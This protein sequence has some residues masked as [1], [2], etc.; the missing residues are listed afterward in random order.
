MEELY[1][2]NAA[3]VYHFL[4]SKCRDPEAAEDLTQETFL[5]ALRSI[6]SYN[7]S[8]KI[9]VWLCQIAKHLLYQYWERRKESVPLEDDWM[10]SEEPGVERQV[11]AREELLDVL[12]RLHQL[13]VNMREVVYLRISGDLSFKEIGRIMGKSENWARVNFFRAKELLKKS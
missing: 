8:C 2:E 11:L 12:G 1:K 6:D 9:S 10:L 13:P 4:L 3:L 5:Q 7:G